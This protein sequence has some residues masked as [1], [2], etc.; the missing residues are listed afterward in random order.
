M[1]TC[2]QCDSGYPDSHTTCPTHGLPLNEICK[3][4]RTIWFLA[5]ILAAASLPASAQSDE[6]PI[7]LP[8]P[9]PI[10]KP[11]ARAT[12]LVLCD[13]ACNWKLDGKALGRLDAGDSVTVPLSLG[14]HLVDA[15]TLDGLDEVKKEIE[16][17]TTGQMNVHLALQSVQAAR[18][19]AEQEVKDKAAQ[20]ARDNTAREQQER[21]RVARE[22]AEGVWID[23]KTNL[24]WTKKDNGSNVTWQ[25]SMDYCRNLQLA[26]YSDWHLPAI[27]EL[28]G[29]YNA[30]ANFGGYHVKGNLILSG[31]QWSSSRGNASGEF[32]K[33]NFYNVT[34]D[35]IST[36]VDFHYTHRAL[37]VRHSGEY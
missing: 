31:Y 25:Q 9:K 18:L 7:L 3:W 12:L 36:P 6:G 35:R 23:P 27:D 28:Q 15:T 34:G 10:A 8:K 19:K 30:N 5:L 16:I 1:K 32:W 13:L 33:L 11:A 14:R 2:P 37:C 21:E 26:G 17:K 24:M 4:K 29:I 20:E 22:L